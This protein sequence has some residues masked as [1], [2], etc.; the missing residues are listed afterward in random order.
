MSLREAEESDEE[1]VPQFRRYLSNDAKSLHPI[2]KGFGPTQAKQLAKELTSNTTLTSINLNGNRIG[3]AGTVA[4]AGALASNKTLSCL[5]LCR[6]DIG[7]VGLDALGQAMVQNA[8]LT[9][10]NLRANNFG[11]AGLTSFANAL[12]INEGLKRLKLCYNSLGDTGAATLAGALTSNTSLISLFLYS[13]GIG[14]EG[15]RELGEATKVNAT[16]TTLGLEQNSIGDE[17]ALVLLDALTTCN[18][19]LTKAVFTIANNVSHDL[20]FSIGRIVRANREGIRLLHAESVLDLSSKAI[21]QTMAKT[22]AKELASNT[23]VTAL[24]MNDNLV[25][26]AGCLAIASA[27]GQNKVLTKLFLNGNRIGLAGVTTLAK[28]LQ[29]KTCIQ[30]LGLGRNSF[31]NN[32]AVVMA[33]ALGSNGTLTRV[34]LNGNSITDGGAVALLATLKWYNQ[35]LTVLSLEDNMVISPVLLEEIKGMLASRQVLKSFLKCLCMPLE[36]TLMP[37]VIHAVQENSDCLEARGGPIFHLVRAAAVN[38]SKVIKVTLPGHMSYVN[39][40]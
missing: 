29:T 7:D 30:V 1:E 3:D 2:W 10:L 16:L 37:V 25:V 40:S 22:I 31:G 34:D 36:K 11:T 17:G 13:N 23:T 32:G 26:D 19:T 27:L 5:Q 12:K 38:D 21:G 20:L 24:F 18:T 15:M 28:A 9:E 4:L 8:S 33:D 35:N 39:A 14:N 6:N